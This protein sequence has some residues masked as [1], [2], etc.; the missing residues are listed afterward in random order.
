MSSLPEK[1]QQFPS[2]RPQRRDA[3]KYRLFSAGALVFTFFALHAGY[4]LSF[5]SG[6]HVP[7]VGSVTWGGECERAEQECGSIM[8][9]IIIDLAGQG[10]AAQKGTIFLNP[11]GPGN[12]GTQGASQDLAAYL[13]NEWDILGFDPRGIHRTSPQV[14]CFARIE[15]FD[16]FNANTVLEQ[17]F[18]VKSL[19]NLS[20]PA[21]EA[22]LTE[23]SRQF[24][25]LKK[26][27][28]EICAKTM[29]DDLR[30]MG[31]ATVVRDMAFMASVFDGE[32]AKI[33]FFGGSYGS[34][35]GAYLVNMLPER[36]GFVIIDGIV[37][38]INWSMEPSYKWTANWLASVEKTY[39]FFLETCAKAGPAGCSLSQYTT[40]PY[41]KIEAR[42][43]SFFD[44]LVV[45]PMAVPFARR[46]GYLSSGAARGLLLMY[47]EQP[48]QWP[49][50]AH[51]FAAALAGNGT[52]L[53]DK[54]IA[55]GHVRTPNHDLVRSAVAC[56]DAP[57]P[58]SP[59]DIPTAE[60]LAHELMAVLRDV[61]PHFG[62][63]LSIGEPDGGCEYWAARAPE[64][65]SGPWN[66]SLAWP[67]LIVSNTVRRPAGCITPIQSGLRI[68]ALMGASSR[69]V[70]QDGP[71]HCSSSLPA[72]CTLKVIQAYFAGTLP[73][74]GTLCP[75]AF[76]YFPDSS[77]VVGLEQVMR[78]GF[79]GEE[80]SILAG[81]R[82]METLFRRQR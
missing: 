58:S 46:P 41:T 71:G 78:V 74:N 37:D 68:N 52:L 4:R 20:D 18:T 17:G 33:N 62:A 75:T 53:F 61:S 50:A 3:L 55:P 5:G 51:A 25:A 48:T 66:A 80:E 32:D 6:T 38:P 19:S 24:I 26:A 34:I 60:D 42:L 77:E 57:P 79:E 69:L 10:D 23:Q 21:V 81:A 73:A 15:D 29:G 72:P 49:E 70:I 76:D 30:Y 31:S 2:P 56:L 36:A 9:C 28:A 7:K 63:S 8:D 43:E 1:L 40:E 47:L 11:G 82:A 65:F 44:A 35:L 13:G 22:G 12:S 64:R 45:T 67:M 16:L 14:K 39:Q 54:L 27:Q 59:R